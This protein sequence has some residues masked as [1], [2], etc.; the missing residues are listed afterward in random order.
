MGFIREGQF[1][2]LFSASLPLGERERGDDVP[3]T[4]EPLEVGTTE[5]RDPR[6]PGCVAANTSRQDG[7]GF[8]VT[9]PVMQCVISFRPSP[10]FSSE[11]R[12]GPWNPAY[13]SQLSLPGI[14]PRL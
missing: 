13:T 7:A 10:L 5:E 11:R 8:D 14:V 3:T 4:F 2:L 9:E 1:Q 12:P 6:D